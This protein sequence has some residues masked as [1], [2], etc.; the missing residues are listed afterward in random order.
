MARAQGIWGAEAGDGSGITFSLGADAS[1]LINNSAVART[2]SY[3]FNSKIT[4]ASK[5]CAVQIQTGVGSIG[6]SGESYDFRARIY[7]QIVSY[8]NADNL[9]IGGL[10]GGG[11]SA[12]QHWLEIDTAGHMR[13]AMSGVS[14]TAYSAEALA[15][16]TW[17]ELRVRSNGFAATTG[18][19][20]SARGRGLVEVYMDA[21][22]LVKRFETVAAGITAFIGT[23]GGS[24]AHAQNQSAAD[25]WATVAA[26]ASGYAQGVSGGLYNGVRFDQVISETKVNSVTLY[27]SNDIT[28]TYQE[29]GM[30]Q[31]G[32]DLSNFNH[33]NVLGGP[34]TIIAGQDSTGVTCTREVN[35]DDVVW[36]FRTG[37]DADNNLSVEL[38]IPTHVVPFYVTGQGAHDGF[39]PSGAYSNVA[40]I[41]RGANTVASSTPGAI[42]TYTHA[43]LA[44]GS[45]A[46]HIRCYINATSVSSDHYVLIGSSTYSKSF[47]AATGSSDISTL[48]VDEPEDPF[49]LKSVFDTLEFGVE[50][51]TSGKTVTIGNIL[52]EVLA[53]QGVTIDEAIAPGD[54][55]VTVGLTTT[56]SGVSISPSGVVLATS[57]SQG[58]ITQAGGANVGSGVPAVV[59]GSVGGAVGT[60]MGAGSLNAWNLQRLDIKPRIEET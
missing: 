36:D 28:G 31:G 51:V 38:P 48:V 58:F 9:I 60:G 47:T 12:P 41:P 56:G 59:I 52:L 21:G 25:A 18:K 6:S 57:L 17:Y 29:V 5:P 37:A 22:T 13:M 44:A 46:A 43:A 50:V 33:Y 3:Y 16:S 7:F 4:S 40:E 54:T 15:L 32:L 26:H 34:P 19:T 35:Y 20:N 1:L 2:G 42:T 39:A 27:S 14:P 49:M 55:T 53:Y 30:L 24:P 10:Y 8:P 11:A 45:T 23:D